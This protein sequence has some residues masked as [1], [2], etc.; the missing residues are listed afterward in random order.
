MKA[1][2]IKQDSRPFN[3]A[4]LKD[5]YLNAVRAVYGYAVTCHKCQGGEW[6]EVF[7][8]QDSKIAGIPRPG[9]YQWWYTALTRAKSRF[10]LTKIWLLSE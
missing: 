2:G 9:I 3:D 10:F 8:Y 7:L 1:L 6:E 4:M 5:P